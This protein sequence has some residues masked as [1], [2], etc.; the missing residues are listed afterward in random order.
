M[1]C[2][3]QCLIVHLSMYSAAAFFV[4]LSLLFLYFRLFKPDKVTRWLVYGGIL[5]NGLFY[6]VIIVIHA[7]V[8]SPS[9][10]QSNTDI[11]WLTHFEKSQ[12]VL[13]N[14]TVVQ[15][16]F[17]ILSDIYL[18]V[19][20]IRSIFQLRLSLRRKFG[21]SSIFLI[22]ILWVIIFYLW[23]LFGDVNFFQCIAVSCSAANL[24]YRIK[25]IND[26]DYT[27]SLLLFMVL[28]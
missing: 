17:G 9:P 21:V 8:V 6:F 11:N 14:L 23:H 1:K 5:G 2:G 4:K 16:V 13:H 28:A 7:T 24:G 25:F 27:W 19:I 10:A 12:P 26:R 18:F 3:L 15:G 22:G 20:P